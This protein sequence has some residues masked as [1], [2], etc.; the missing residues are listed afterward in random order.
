M[1]CCTHNVD[2]TPPASECVPAEDQ[3]EGTETRDQDL[4]SA[5][6]EDLGSAM[7]E[8]L[9]S[10]VEGLE[11]FPGDVQIFFENILN[12]PQNPTDTTNNLK[13]I[14]TNIKSHPNAKFFF[15][16]NLDENKGNISN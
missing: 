3:P 15:G 12:L 11:L 10:K 14:I 2:D 1:S 13:E 9:R 7:E 5:M 4:S 16:Q 6:E 8:D